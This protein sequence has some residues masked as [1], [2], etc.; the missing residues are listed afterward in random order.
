MSAKWLRRLI[1]LWPPLF[2]SGIRATY[3]SPDFRQV[4]VSLKLR[5]YNRNAVGT[6]FG[7]SLFAM[8]DPW[9]MLMLMHN[10]GDKYYVWDKSAEIDYMAPGRDHVSAHFELNQEQLEDICSQTASGDKYLPTFTVEVC[11]RQGQC[12]ARVRRQLYVRLKPS[13]R[14]IDVLP[15]PRY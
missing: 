9:Y 2:F 1:N 12:V 14:A 7:G 3:I 8:T 10:L 6:Q 5:F 11:D 15:P 13:H 4:H